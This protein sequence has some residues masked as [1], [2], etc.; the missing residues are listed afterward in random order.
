MAE[1]NPNATTLKKDTVA[2]ADILSFTPPAGKRELKQST[3]LGATVH[4]H[5]YGLPEYDA[6]TGQIKYDPA[7][8]NALQTAFN[9]GA[10]HTWLVTLEDA[11]EIEWDGVMTGFKPG[12]SDP[13]GMFLTADIEIG[14]DSMPTV[15][16][17]T[18]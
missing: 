10:S 16:L 6:A 1:I 3:V 15:T 5:A 2:I 9:A 17:D 14:C 11:T 7:I 18:P 8:H 12:A 13:N 4:T